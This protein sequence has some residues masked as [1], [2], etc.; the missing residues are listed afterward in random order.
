MQLLH[1]EFEEVFRRLYFL[2]CEYLNVIDGFENYSN[3]FASHRN[4]RGE[5]PKSK[6]ILV[7]QNIKYF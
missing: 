6:V 7:P 4:T 2:L 5:I 1:K 3:S